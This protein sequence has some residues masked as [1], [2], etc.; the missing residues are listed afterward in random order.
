MGIRLSDSA[1]CRVNSLANGHGIG[2][3][4]ARVWAG[5][6]LISDIRAVDAVG[7]SEQVR[8]CRRGSLDVSGSGNDELCGVMAALAMTVVRRSR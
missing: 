8:Q 7:N 6:G 5:I 3:G 2:D 1:V 4:S